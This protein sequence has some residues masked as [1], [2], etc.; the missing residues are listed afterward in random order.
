MMPDRSKSIIEA[1][2]HM[3]EAIASRLDGGKSEAE[4]HPG[5][6]SAADLPFTTF[7]RFIRSPLTGGVERVLAF[8]NDEHIRLVVPDRILNLPNPTIEDLLSLGEDELPYFSSHGPLTDLYGNAPR[9]TWVSTTFPLGVESLAASLTWPG[10]EDVPF[11]YDQPPLG[12]P[13]ETEKVKG[14]GYSK[15][16][17]YLNDEDYFVTIGPS[18]PRIAPLKNGNAQFWVGSIGI[19]AV[20]YGKFTGARG[21]STYVGSGYVENWHVGSLADQIQTLNRGFRA[22]IGTYVKFVEEKHLADA[23]GG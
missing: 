5:D 4:R 16:A 14:H 15:Q 13:G 19:I 7:E 12:P 6:G 17:Y 18:L 8:N 9:G 2:D 22:M 1:L 21:I 23:D 11:P 20:G 10:V 3:R